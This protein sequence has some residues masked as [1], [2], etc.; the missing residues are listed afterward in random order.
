[1]HSNLH[2]TI[3]QA[4]AAPAASTL[5]DRDLLARDNTRLRNEL[6]GVRVALRVVT[7]ELRSHTAGDAR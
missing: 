3:E 1:M 2:A 4:I 5:A 6:E 7:D